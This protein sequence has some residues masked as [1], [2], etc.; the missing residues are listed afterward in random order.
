[1]STTDLGI[2]ADAVT[3]A[4]LATVGGIVVYAVART[5]WRRDAVQQTMKLGLSVAALVAVALAGV[6]LWPAARE[7]VN[8]VAGV[9]VDGR[10]IF[11]DSS[12]DPAATVVDAPAAPDVGPASDS[13]RPARVAAAP[14]SGSGPESGSPPSDDG[15]GPRPDGPP[16]DPNPPS[17]TPSTGPSL[18]PPPPSP[19]TTTPPPPTTPPSS[20]PPSSGEPQPEPVDPSASRLTALV[21]R[22]RAG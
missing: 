16:N 12:Q 17:D 5:L 21:W 2:L 22:L 15:G 4:I 13:K 20:P 10:G 3:F 8:T 9:E 19:T 18:P 11:E 14:Q 1:V 7:S 6:A